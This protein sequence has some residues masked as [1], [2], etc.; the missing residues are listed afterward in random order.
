MGNEI[1]PNYSAPQGPGTY[2]VKSSLGE[3]NA[4]EVKTSPQKQEC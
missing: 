4:Q 2:K 3:E 1:Y